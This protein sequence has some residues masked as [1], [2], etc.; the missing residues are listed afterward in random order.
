MCDSLSQ[1]DSKQCMNVGIRGMEKNY[2]CLFVFPTALQ[3]TRRRSIT[4]A[5]Y[6]KETKKTENLPIFIL[7]F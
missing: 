6:R 3:D 4:D 1:I 5:N 7:L 2:L